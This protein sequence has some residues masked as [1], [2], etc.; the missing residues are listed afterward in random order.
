[1]YEWYPNQVCIFQAII[2]ILLE[3]NYDNNNNNNNNNDDDDDDDNDNDNNNN[4]NNNYYYYYYCAPF[5][6]HKKII[7]IC[8]KTYLCWRN[9]RTSFLSLQ[10]MQREQLMFH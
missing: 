6:C 1:M 10:E 3:K 2:L 7:I 5:P 9:L 8:Y 4:N